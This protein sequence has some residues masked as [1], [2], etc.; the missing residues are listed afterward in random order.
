MNISNFLIIRLLLDVKHGVAGLGKD[1][2]CQEWV[3]EEGGAEIRRQ[4]RRSGG[5]VRRRLTDCVIF[6]N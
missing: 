5:D 6:S 4:N 2:W 3:E 1:V